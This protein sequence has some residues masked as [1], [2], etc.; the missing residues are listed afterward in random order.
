MASSTR[1][2]ELALPMKLSSTSARMRPKVRTWELDLS[3]SASTPPE[4]TPPSRHAPP[5]N[6]TVT[7]AVPRADRLIAMPS[8]FGK[9]L[10]YRVG[11]GARQRIHG[12]VQSRRGFLDTPW[13]GESPLHRVRFDRR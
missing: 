11:P 12:F 5:R 13:G 10:K 6:K 2:S 8:T 3:T 7:P 4:S 9:P 1:S